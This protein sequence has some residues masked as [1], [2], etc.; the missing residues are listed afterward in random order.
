M[1]YSS[2]S[3]TIEFDNENIKTNC[4]ELQRDAATPSTHLWRLY[5]HHRTSVIILSRFSIYLRIPLALFKRF[6]RCRSKVSALW[7]FE[8]TKIRLKM[9]TVYRCVYVILIPFMFLEFSSEIALFF[10]SFM[11][12]YVFQIKKKCGGCAVLFQNWLLTTMIGSS[13][14]MYDNTWQ[15]WKSMHDINAYT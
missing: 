5:F 8:C 1:D 12:D 11:E 9:C 10:R 13:Y 14:K 3:I 6:D 2:L 15:E 7:I 4:H